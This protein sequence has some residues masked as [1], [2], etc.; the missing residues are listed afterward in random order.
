MMN[1]IKAVYCIENYVTKDLYIGS[2]TDY[3]SRI[4]QHVYNLKNNK[5]KS[6]LLQKHWNDQ[7]KNDFVFTILE[8][9][10][11]SNELIN[12]EQFFMD[13]LNSN[14]NTAKK[15]GSNLGVKHSEETKNKLSILGIGNKNGTGTIWTDDAKKNMS[16]IK[17]NMSEET[18]LKMSESAK[19]RKHSELT[20][21]KMSN[22]RKGKPVSEETRIKLSI[23]L[24]GKIVSDQ[25]KKNMSNAFKKSMTPERL[26]KMSELA[27]GK[28]WTFAR[29][30]A[31][32]LR[33]NIH[34]K[35]L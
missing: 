9:I 30:L 19:K 5:H 32:N 29:R 35:T 18:R 24:T 21:I 16:I 11:N 33:F 2:T 31:Y 20:K 25:T 26:K 34:E 22:N 4:R 7:D 15:A 27:K 6:K 28:P 13:S 3:K 23:A 1:K 10:S 17:K 8:L 14:Y 12:R